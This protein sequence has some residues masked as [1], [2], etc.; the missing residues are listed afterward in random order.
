[1]RVLFLDIDGVLNS[2]ASMIALGQSRPADDPKECNLDPVACGMLRTILAD[3]GFTHVYV[4][5]T[6]S[7]GKQDQAYFNAMLRHQGVLT[8]STN[9]MI[10]VHH[11]TG[12]YLQRDE[13]IVAA[14]EHYDMEDYLVLDDVNLT[15]QFKAIHVD[16]RDGLSY[17]DYVDICDM[18]NV[19]PKMVLL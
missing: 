15:K 9:V 4:H 1:M 16:S 12:R 19:K 6:W 17:M 8:D 7:G 3:C 11:G 2:A 14:I 5:S 18:Y 13:R 10:A